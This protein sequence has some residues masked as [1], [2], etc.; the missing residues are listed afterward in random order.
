MK[1]LECNNKEIQNMIEDYV[2][3][4]LSEEDRKRVDEHLSHCEYCQ[5]EH[6]ITL[7]MI[8]MAWLLS[9]KDWE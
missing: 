8:D 6:D 4:K 3:G 2:L 1:R 9:Y 7:D 5:E